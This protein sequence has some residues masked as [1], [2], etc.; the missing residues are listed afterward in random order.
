MILVM[1]AGKGI[2]HVA[3]MIRL[4]WHHIYQNCRNYLKKEEI[5]YLNQFGLSHLV[6]FLWESGTGRSLTWA[7]QFMWQKR[8]HWIAETSS[9]FSFHQQCSMEILEHKKY[10][11]LH[12]TANGSQRACIIVN[13]PEQNGWCFCRWHFKMPFLQKNF[14]YY[15]SSFLIP[16]RYTL[17]MLRFQVNNNISQQGVVSFKICWLWCPGA[18]EPISYGNPEA[19]LIKSIFHFR[20]N[21]R[22]LVITRIGNVCHMRNCMGW[23]VNLRVI[24]CWLS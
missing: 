17:Q 6:F 23:P 18:E 21:L 16:C 22:N 20:D 14:L 24:V 10:P 1:I 11:D 19:Y 5:T 12:Q 3:R 13:K 9:Y 8:W 7:S 4:R 2:G 15:D